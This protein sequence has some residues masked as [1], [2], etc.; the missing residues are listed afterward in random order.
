ML[1]CCKCNLKQEEEGFYKNKKSANGFNPMCKSCY[2]QYHLTKYVPLKPLKESPKHYIYQ[3]TKDG[4]VVYIGKG[5]GNRVNHLKSGRS[6]VYHANECYFLGVPFNVE[7]VEYFD[8]RLGAL[9]KEAELIFQIKP[10]WN[11]D[12]RNVSVER[13]GYNGVHYDTGNKKAW[14]CRFKCNG[15]QI[16]NGNY[17]TEIEAAIAYDEYVKEHNLNKPLNFPKEEWSD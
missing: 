17:E 12:R 3:A 8:S 14:R 5:V 13:V 15:I 7:I 9:S 16:S 6:H 11:I 10:I 1:I 2:K 4:E